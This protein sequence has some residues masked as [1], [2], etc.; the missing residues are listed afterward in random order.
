[1]PTDKDSEAKDIFK[2][3]DQNDEWVAQAVRT[4]SIENPPSAKYQRKG[5]I[6]RANFKRQYGIRTTRRERCGDVPMW[7]KEFVKWATEAKR[8]PEEEAK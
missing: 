3:L 8:L 1:M 5:L 2:A 7:E 4:Y 6:Q